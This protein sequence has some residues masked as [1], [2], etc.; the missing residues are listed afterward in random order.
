MA[1][2]ILPG[3]KFL[4]Q[5]SWSL[6][7]CLSVLTNLIYPAT[8]T[9]IGLIGNAY[10]LGGQVKEVKDDLQGMKSDLQWVKSGLQGVKSDVEA[11][12]A[13]QTDIGRRDMSIAEKILRDRGK[14]K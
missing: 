11:L 12:L 8:L 2:P 14:K 3:R 6:L 10:I 13:R 9:L 4:S 7:I 5:S 1:A